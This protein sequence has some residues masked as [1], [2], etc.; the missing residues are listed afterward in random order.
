MRFLYLALDLKPEESHAECIHMRE[1]VRNI[2]DLGHE[3][4]LLASK[5]SSEPENGFGSR[6]TLRKVG[7]GGT[8]SELR[9]VIREIRSFRPEVIYERRFLPKISAAASVLTGIPAVVEINGL[10]EDEIRLQR[11]AHPSFRAGRFRR[12]L[13]SLAFRR[14]RRVV[15]V[16]KRMAAELSR[17]YRVP[18]DRIE[19]I[20]NGANT[21]LFRPLDKMDCRRRL[22]L[23]LGQRLVCFEGSLY[24]WHD[25]T[26]LLAAMH[27]IRAENVSID[28]IIV[29]DGPLRSSLE[30][31]AH[32]LDLAGVVKFVGE[33]PYEDVPYY[34]GASDLGVAPLTRDRNERI[35]VSPMKVYEYVAC[36]R[37]VVVTRLP[38]IAEWVERER[39]GRLVEPNDPEDLARRILDTVGDEEMQKRLE[40]QGPEIVQ[41]EHSWSAV[42]S[43]I[44]DLSA[45]LVRAPR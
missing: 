44:V 4:R 36:G 12:Y 30:S 23:E 33:V 17:Q 7:G 43:R 10:V 14:M 25:V 16:T 11:R 27:H 15:S 26:T 34:I 29:G 45:R 6:I 13:H 39:I 2:A 21:L 35:G 18:Q 8:L 37:P 1:V 19:V 38:G 22:G 40:I 31:Q 9:R 20:E 42:A 41:R 24:P 32:Q 3:V 5:A 28:L